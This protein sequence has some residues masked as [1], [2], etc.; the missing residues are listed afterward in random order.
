[1]DEIGDGLVVVGGPQ[2]AGKT[3]F[4]QAVR[5][6][7]YGIGSG[8][9][10]PPA[11]DT[12]RVQTIA[13]HKGKDYR[14][15]LEGHADPR[16]TALDSETDIEI[17]DVYGLSPVQYRQLF[18]ISLDELRRVPDGIGDE[19]DLAEILLGAAYGDIGEIPEIE[20]KFD[21]RASEIGLTTGKPSNST[22][23]FYGAH[24]QIVEGIEERKEAREQV[25]T[26]YKKR[27]E[28]ETVEEE[29]A[30]LSGQITEH[31]QKKD[32]LSVVES[33]FERVREWQEL[34]E[35]LSD[36]DLDAARAFPTEDI[37]KADQLRT[38]LE[39]KQ[40]DLEAAKREFHEQAGRGDGEA[41]EQE[42]LD[43]E[44]EI[45]QF[46]R[47]VSGWQKTREQLREQ[48]D[49]LEER[50]NQLRNR[51]ESLHPDWDETLDTIESVET[52]HVTADRIDQITSRYQQANQTLKQKRQEKQRKKKRLDETE[53]R[54]SEL[55]SESDDGNVDSFVRNVG[56]VA[57]GAVLI[58]VGASAVGFVI[59]GLVGAFLLLVGG[60]YYLTQNLDLETETGS[61][62]DSL[63]NKKST[64]RSD[65]AEIEADIE[66]AEAKCEEA[67]SELESVR[68][69]YGLP[70]GVS[71]EG[72]Q[73]FHESVGKLQQEVDDLRRE[74][75]ELRNETEEFEATLR[76]VGGV[77]SEITTFEWDDDAPLDRAPAL[78][79][80]IEKLE[81][82]LAAAKEVAAVRREIGNV[83]D[84]IES[85]LSKTEDVPTVAESNDSATAK[86]QLERFIER[87]KQARTILDYDNRRDELESDLQRRMRQDGARTAFDPV[88]EDDEVWLSVLERVVD[89]HVDQEAVQEAIKEVEETIESLQNELEDARKTKAELEQELSNLK[90]DEDI[91]KAEQKIEAGR[92][93][94]RRYGEQYAVNRIAEKMIG[95]L[96]Q[97]F[98]EEVAD[99]LIEDASE[100]F[101]R[102]TNEYEGIDHNDDFENLDFKAIRDDDT[103]LGRRELSRATAEQLF[104]SM[105]I[106]RIRDIDTSLPV[107][108]DDAMT[109]FDPAHQRRTLQTLDELA[110]TNQIFLLT[111]HPE[112]VGRVADISESAQY[113][114]LDDGKFDGGFDTPTQVNSLLTERAATTVSGD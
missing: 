35:K 28:Y 3:T 100:I 76:R 98:I 39:Q 108:V 96:Y 42:L 32:R 111:C 83:E 56:F 23:K 31:R 113:W 19:S 8:D 107:V 60:L 30:A 27:D 45:E 64:L 69:R 86:S 104:L 75:S 95:R 50:R 36:A 7:G 4:M 37:E 43:N 2:R 88:R 52:D 6:L 80:E 54:L 81:N 58:A 11:S 94:L 53:K 21:E 41:Y 70:D 38:R 51:I 106:A 67:A 66:A 47:Q 71:P 73:D 82:D 93:E 72:L 91:T 55:D 57:G 110:R 97:R 105:R 5:R 14:L 62:V 48:D 78:F 90:S 109:N 44:E 68:E 25:D 84:E 13:E 61:E 87:G 9:N 79:D 114:S 15:S 24:Q 112:L 99:P 77:I 92:A 46:A 63:M 49:A 29:I 20:A 16:F 12:Y 1:M 40:D 59:G 26:Y 10:I 34:R 101:H 89:Q 102:V 33:E 22:S 17:D 103:K 65:I 85:L 18:T 74:M